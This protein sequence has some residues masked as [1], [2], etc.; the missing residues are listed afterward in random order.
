MND[1]LPK[2]M[3]DGLAHG[4]A[5]AEHPSADALTAF[6]EHVLTEGETHSVANHLAHCAECREVVFLASGAAEEAVAR[7]EGELV[8]ASS[9]PLGKLA[10]DD[11]APAM[12]S[13]PATLKPQP[14][15]LSRWLW[16][17][18]VAAIFLISAGYFVR[19]RFAALP[20]GPQL[21]ANTTQET[22]S[23]TAGQ[24][25]RAVG[26]LAMPRTAPLVQAAKSQS[27]AAVAKIA[28][29]TKVPAAGEE[30]VEIRSLIQ[31][32]VKTEETQ[33]KTETLKPAAESNALALGGA[34]PAATPRSSGFVAS[35]SDAPPP[36]RF[37]P[38]S[39]A[40]SQWVVLDALQQFHPGWRITTEGHLEHLTSG[41]WTRVLGDHPGAFRTVTV[42]GSNVW[43]GGSGRS[44][45][46]SADA[47]QHWTKVSLPGE[48]GSET[49]A[50]ISLRFDDPQ[51]GVVLADNGSSYLTSDGGATWTRQ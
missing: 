40:S 11:G 5:P 48:G 30:V 24:Q 29:S 43:A 17:A 42:V 41:G 37:T 51:H 8:A 31:P 4:A 47:G 19:Q 33:A 28:P 25:S 32:N 6:L 46:H 3:L 34:M 50:I 15:R 10:I 35:P 16:A 22:P 49:T 18:P 39:P 27:R 12:T 13:A 20:A 26:P 44:L 9:R 23:E 45:F 21:A 38:A 1:K 7:Y 36:M 14:R 2:P